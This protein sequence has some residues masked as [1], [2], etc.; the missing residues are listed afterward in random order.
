MPTTHDAV[1]AL[2]AAGGANHSLLRNLL[3]KRMAYC[4][5]ADED[6]QDLVAVDPQS[7]ATILAL[8]QNGRVYALD[9]ED[10]T[11]PHDGTSVLV[12]YDSRR[13]KLDDLSVPY[14]VLDKDLTAPPDDPEIGD[15]YLLVEPGTGDWAELDGIVM[16]TGHGWEEISL[17]VGRMVYVADEDAYYHR[18]PTGE[19]VAGL[20]VGS[21]SAGSLT[22]RHLLRGG[23]LV[24]WQVI[25]QTTQ[26]PPE[27]PT[28]GD[29][30]IAAAG[31]TG[32]WAGWDGSIVRYENGG[33]YRYIPSTG[34]RGYDVNLNQNVE[35]QSPNWVIQAS[36][37]NQIISVSTQGNSALSA[38]GSNAAGYNFSPGTAPT[39]TTS[40]RLVETLTIDIQAQ[41]AG[42]VFDIEYQASITAST[43]TTAGGTNLIEITSGIF[44]D[45][46]TNAAD[47]TKSV[48]T[49]SA[50]LI[51]PANSEL[52][53]K[54][55]FASFSISIG[56]TSPHTLT[57]IHFP[58][59]AS[60]DITGGSVTL[61]RRRLTARRR[62]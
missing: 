31:S 32:A 12:S 58:R 4:L 13:Y 59:W 49:S 3:V 33:W 24:T 35:Y 14:H 45:S 17:P 21:I 9:P 47:W 56:D 52:A 1:T 26:S 44:I 34:W 6:A 23:D 20:G 61:A 41:F 28:D 40:R 57:I 25:N 5:A 38:N 36:G 22:P 43:L 37:Y 54:N 46:T 10:T 29:T 48:S 16:L 39:Q 60:H 11:S 53:T 27:S 18:R 19:I 8:I 15:A 51:S 50:A 2:P 62:A 7:G 42:Q 30:Y 55:I